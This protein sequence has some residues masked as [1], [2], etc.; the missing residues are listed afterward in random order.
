MGFPLFDQPD[1]KAEWTFSAVVHKDW[2]VVSND[3]VREE[4]DGASLLNELTET[5]NFLK[6]DDAQMEIEEVSTF[7]FK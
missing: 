2:T 4:S 7:L 1:L 6:T 5:R 3:Y